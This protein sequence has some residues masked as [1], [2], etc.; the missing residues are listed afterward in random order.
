MSGHGDVYDR[1]SRK[2]ISWFD[3]YCTYGSP[4]VSVSSGSEIIKLMIFVSR[5]SARGVFKPSDLANVTIDGS[6]IGKSN[7]LKHIYTFY[8]N[9]LHKLPCIETETFERIKAF[10]KIY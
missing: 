4:G 6:R 3:S 10:D 1:T 2:L 5:L 7:L 9:I 8:T